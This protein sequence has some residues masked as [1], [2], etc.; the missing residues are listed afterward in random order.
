M[1]R[2]VS[3]II[4]FFAPFIVVFAQQTEFSCRYFSIKYPQ[5]WTAEVVGNPNSTGSDLTD[6]SINIKPIDTKIGE[7]KQNIAINMDPSID[8]STI[9]QKELGQFKSLITNQY[10]GVSFMTAPK[11]VNYKGLNGIYMEYTAMLAGYKARMMQCIIHKHN[12]FTYFITLG[13]DYNKAESQLEVINDIMDTMV[14][15]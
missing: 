4:F 9:G 2:Y 14:I 7:P 1:R 6:A 15:K 10:S 5:S 3:S 12:G 8:W 13:V 11:F